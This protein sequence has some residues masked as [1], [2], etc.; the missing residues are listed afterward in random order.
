MSPSNPPPPKELIRLGILLHTAIAGASFAAVI[1]LAS[2]ESIDQ[3]LLLSIFCFAIAIPASVAMVFISQLAI[4]EG[5]KFSEASQMNKKRLPLLSYLIPVAEQV[6]FFVG[7][8]ALFWSFNPIASI[9]F[10]GMSLLALMA[11]KQVEKILLGRQP[12]EG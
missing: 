8:L 5:M 12:S 11:V 7:V 9:L 1:Q 3:V 2:R 6:S 4:P 10:F